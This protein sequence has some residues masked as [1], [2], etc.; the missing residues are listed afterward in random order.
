MSEWGLYLRPDSPFFEEPRFTV[1]EAERFCL[2]RADLPSGWHR[3]RAVD[4]PWTSIHGPKPLEDQGWKIHVATVPAEADAVLSTVAAVCLEHE[5]S[6]KYL[7]TSGILRSMSRKYAPRSSSGKFITIYPADTTDFDRIAERLEA[8]LTGGAGSVALTD[9]QLGT[10]PLGARYGAFREQ[11]LGLPDGQDTLALRAPDDTLVADRR[12]PGF[13]APEGIPLPRTVREAIDRRATSAGG[14]YLPYRI[15]RALHLSNGGGVYEAFA[16]D[17][18]RVALKEGRRHTGYGLDGR[19]A[20]QSLADEARALR[21]LAGVPGVPDLI[22]WHS[23][24]DRDFLVQEFIEGARGIEFV[25]RHHPGVHADTDPDATVDYAGR[26]RRIVAGIRNTLDQMHRRGWS[27]GD[28]HPGN[29]LIGPGDRVSLVDFETATDDPAAAGDR[30]TV[31]PGFRVDGLDALTA[32]VRRLDRIHLWALR[33]ESTFWEFSDAILDQSITL[34]QEKGLPASTADSLRGGLR[35]DRGSAHW[36]DIALAGEQLTVPQLIEWGEES[37]LAAAERGTGPS[38]DISGPSRGFPLAA[39][40]VPW[41]LGGGMAGALWS[42][43]PGTDVRL[44]MLADRV[45]QL[46][47]TSRRVL[48]GLFTGDAGAA[49]ALDRHGVHYGAQTLMA[50]SLDRA[51]DLEHPGL[52][53]GLSGIGIAALRMGLPDTAANLGERALAAI[54]AGDFSPGLLD[55]ASGAALL[56][57]GLYEETGDTAWLDGARNALER[58]LTHLVFRDDGTVLL[59]RGHR[60]LLPDVGQGSLGVAHVAARIQE[61]RDD[62]E[63]ARLRTAAGQT[64]L[65]GAW[66][67]QGL[68]DGRSGAIAYLS[69]AGGRLTGQEQELLERNVRALRRYFVTIQGQVYF[70]GNL[71]MRFSHDFTSGMAGALQALRLVAHP[72]R[73]WLPGMANRRP[74]AATWATTEDQHSARREDQ[75]KEY[76]A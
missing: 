59:D 3:T 19:D 56:A 57:L 37:I 66:A 12:G 30:F 70:P 54:S 65:D 60:R 76:A 6:F 7:P 39:G 20:A 34:A 29:L 41:S 48:P 21:A 24:E 25:A 27:F 44:G 10:A 32:D 23:F 18:R 50:R 31:A 2:D 14:R 17:G 45:H 9:V 26:V 53:A 33:P 74:A 43:D 13:T 49:L 22:G 40:S 35:P 71:C 46:S 64:C 55:G 62:E 69:S 1:L 52:R 38:E 75:T 5:T 28:L 51:D 47:R 68:L 15:T 8:L 63:L 73:E 67:T 61:H 72:E 11:R 58:D 4:R 36:G 42:L 16:Q